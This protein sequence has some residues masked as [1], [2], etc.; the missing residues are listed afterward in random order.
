L[1]VVELKEDGDDSD[2]NRAK[3]RYATEHFE[4][5]NKAQYAATYHMKFISPISYDAFLHSIRDGS[6]PTF[7]S[8]LQAALLATNMPPKT[9]R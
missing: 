2:E 4:R 7:V 9:S 5:I 1:L 3:L 8:T 6:A